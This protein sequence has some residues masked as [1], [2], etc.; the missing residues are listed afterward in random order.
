M[1]LKRLIF[2]RPGETDWNLSGRWQGWVAIPLNEHG[3]L[4][5]QRLGNF[6]RHLGLTKLY[7]SDNR[8]ALETAY[9]IAEHLPFD[10]IP[11]A[12]L[13]ERHIGRW[14]GLIL[15]EIREWYTEEYQQL[16]GDPEHY[17][18]PQGES[19][20]AVKARA[21]EALDDIIQQA[22]ADE[23]EQNIGI[24]THTTT[25]RILMDKLLPQIDLTDTALGNTS[26]TTVTRTEDGGWYCT[27]ANDTS[28]LDGLESRY[29]PEV[30][31]E[32][33]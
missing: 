5:A 20:A 27:A 24:L 30:D 15:P 2:I 14:Q 28:H 6:I 21:F 18:M 12:R 8:R 4:Q 25:L 3:R 31:T 26:V 13:R 33:Q 7:T 10:P 11:D 9:Y 17:Q 23:G 16:M 19:V 32:E 29:M 1:A 22:E